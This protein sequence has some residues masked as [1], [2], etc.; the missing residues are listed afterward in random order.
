MA[1]GDLTTKVSANTCR[2]YWPEQE[3]SMNYRHLL[4]LFAPLVLALP[5]SA[6]EWPASA[7]AEFAREC[8]A[9]AQSKHSPAQLQAYCDCAATKVSSE[10]SEAEL[11]AMDQQA[12]PDPAMQKRLIAASNSCTSKLD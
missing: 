8:I 3:F 4:A 6:A 12:A 11:Q 7:K 5:A 2:T 1:S 10:F 9:S